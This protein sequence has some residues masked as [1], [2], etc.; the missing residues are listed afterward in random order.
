MQRVETFE[1]VGTSQFIF[2]V[3][4]S[5]VRFRDSE[6]LIGCIKKNL[7]YLIT[8][9]LLVCIR[10]REQQMSHFLL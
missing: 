6:E 9:V 7:K 5:V 10:E 3:D 8:K 1:T 4:V 2:L